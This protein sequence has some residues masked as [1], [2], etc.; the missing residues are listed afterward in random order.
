MV[1]IYKIV[2]GPIYKVN[3]YI[4][5][6]DGSPTS[7]IIDP[8]DESDKILDFFKSRGL[9]P[10]AILLTHSHPDHIG[11]VRQIKTFFNIPL[12]SALTE[13]SDKIKVAGFK[14]GIIETPGHSKDSACFVFKKEK[15]IF[16]GDTLFK[17]FIGRTDLPGGDDSQ[18][19]QS[20]KRLM[21]YPD[22]FRVYPGH[23]S[24]TTIGEERTRNPYVF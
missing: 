23:G 5:A 19:K 9:K 10:G 22:D 7:I 4:L 1:S 18:M 16:T 12:Y 13:L 17:N 3:C 2:V 21:E 8:G 20:L 24:E 14:I 6:I 11:A 15:I